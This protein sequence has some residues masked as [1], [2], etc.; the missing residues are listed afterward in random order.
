M[1]DFR[2][3]LILYAVQDGGYKDEDGI[4]HEGTTTF[5]GDIPCRVSRNGRA[6][7]VILTDGT[8]FVPQYTVYYDID[9]EHDF[10]SG[11]KVQIT[12]AKTGALICTGTVKGGPQ[13]G[14]LHNKIWL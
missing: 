1:I 12:D 11:E 8:T 7:E 10:K 3:H 5:K 4:Y 14:Q 13:K 6:D 9:C 2:P